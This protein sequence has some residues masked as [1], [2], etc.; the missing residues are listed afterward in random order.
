MKVTHKDFPMELTFR[1]TVPPPP[2]G[3]YFK[4][5][6]IL[7]SLNEIPDYRTSTLEKNYIWQPHVGADLGIQLCFV[8]Q[9]SIADKDKDK[10]PPVDP[11]D[12]AFLEADGKS[13]KSRV[14]DDDP[15][16]QPWYFRQTTYIANNPFTSKNMKKGED[17]HAKNLKE[18][19]K[20]LKQINIFDEKFIE[21]SFSTVEHTVVELQKKETKRKMVSCS[22]V[23]PE[24][25]ERVLNRAFI[26]FDEDPI[27][28]AV[29]DGEKTLPNKCYKPEYSL[30]T[31][32]RA[33]EG[34][35]SNKVLHCTL[36]AAVA[37]KDE[38][39]SANAEEITN[40]YKWVRDYT[41]EVQDTNLADCFIFALDESTSSAYYF[42]TETRIDMKKIKFSE[43]QPQEV[44]LDRTLASSNQTADSQES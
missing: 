17:I 22:V 38:D 7:S 42:T 21:E 26:R 14:K 4:N 33:P 6:E 25:T 8:D 9:D 39:S 28:F 15:M 12:K 40:H 29:Q 36:V 13:K 11:L 35:S 34:A 19:E 27:D 43:A 32:S 30:V 37:D 23:L 2:H 31:N 10:I 20:T 3:P 24:D 16:S 41:M 44:I 18:K 5:M 1:N